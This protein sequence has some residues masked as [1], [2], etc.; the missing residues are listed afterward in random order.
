MEVPPLET[1]I[2]IAVPSS[3]PVFCGGAVYLFRHTV[4]KKLP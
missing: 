3:V 4:S 2:G 1:M